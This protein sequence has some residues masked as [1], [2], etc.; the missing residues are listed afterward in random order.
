M[1]QY[2]TNRQK[3]SNYFFKIIF[4]KITSYGIDYNKTISSLMSEVGVSEKMALEFVSSLIKAGKLKE[5]R[6]LELSEEENK[7]REEEKEKI[8]NEAQAV[9]LNQVIKEDD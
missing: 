1:V 6:T 2:E 9:I 4:P 3:L 8:I 5:Y 7:K